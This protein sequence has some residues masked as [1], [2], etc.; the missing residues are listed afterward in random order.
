MNNS[1]TL[2]LSA[3][4]IGWNYTE[5]N[6]SL[7]IISVVILTS[8]LSLITLKKRRTLQTQT[9]KVIP[10]SEKSTE[11]LS[12]SDNIADPNYVPEKL[13]GHKYM[14]KSH[15]LRIK[16]LLLQKTKDFESATTAIFIAGEELESVKYCDIH[17]HFRQNQ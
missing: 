7:H 5:I 8:I 17:K 6:M 14:A 2:S 3:V 12:Y 1:A 15:A 11:M 10:L 16:G 9:E 13:R 4:A